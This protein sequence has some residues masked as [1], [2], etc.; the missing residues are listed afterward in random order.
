[1]GI[2]AAPGRKHE[3]GNGQHGH[4]HRQQ[5]VREQDREVDH[6]DRPLPRERHVADE[7]MV[8]QIAAQKDGRYG[9]RRDHRGPVGP[10]IPTAD[11]D[12]A[13][14]QQQGGQR[15]EGGVD[16][17]QPEGGGGEIHP[18]GVPWLGAFDG[19]LAAGSASTSRISFSS[20]CTRSG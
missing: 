14:R 9:K 5:N 20:S 15:V 1:M 18:A 11:E 13:G 8:S 16:G 17:G 6:P 3:H 12:P 10:P 2:P 4:G 7:G 19:V